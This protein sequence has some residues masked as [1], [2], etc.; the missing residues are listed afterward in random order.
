MDLSHLDEQQQLGSTPSTEA[1]AQQA[2]A[3]DWSWL[4]ESEQPS[5]ASV[6]PAAPAAA[7]PVASDDE[8]LDFAVEE[9]AAPAQAPVQPAL[10]PQ[11]APVAP[12][13]LDWVL[14]ET[15]GC[16]NLPSRSPGCC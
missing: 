16:P 10:E 13:E 1:A 9:P 11:A 12:E 15:P 5:A 7:E 8:W 3:D 6:A 14:D 2:A 4:E